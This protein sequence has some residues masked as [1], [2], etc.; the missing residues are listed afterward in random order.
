MMALYTVFGTQMRSASA[1]Y[2]WAATRSPATSAVSLLLSRA[3][4]SQVVV[5]TMPPFVSVDRPVNY[6]VE[7]L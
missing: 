2:I 6:L 7:G 1:V 5:L 4:T 3:S